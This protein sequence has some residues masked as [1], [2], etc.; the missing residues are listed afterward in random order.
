MKF[1][2][3]FFLATTLTLQSD[4]TCECFKLNVHRDPYPQLYTSLSRCIFDQ[5][6]EFVGYLNDLELRLDYL[7]IRVPANKRRVM[8]YYLE[9]PIFYYSTKGIHNLFRHLRKDF[10]QEVDAM[11]RYHI[12]N[13]SDYQ[14]GKLHCQ[15]KENGIAQC[16]PNNQKKLAILEQKAKPEG[17]RA[18]NNTEKNFYDQ[19]QKDIE[20]CMLRHESPQAFYERGTYHFLHG[21]N[22]LAIQDG[23]KF[24]KLT[25]KKAGELLSNIY[26]QVGQAHSESLSYDK[27]ITTL[28]KAIEA[29]PEN[30]E[31]VFERAV[32]EFELGNFDLSFSDYLSSEKRSRD[33]TSITSDLF[34]YGAGLTLGAL[35]GGI[36]AGEDFIPSVLSSIH[37]LSQGLW[38]FAADPLNASADF[39][40]AAIDC[41]SFIREHTPKENAM[42]LV[43]E[44]RELIENWNDL[45]VSERGGT[46]G[47]F[48]GKYGVEIF[49]GVGVVKGMQAYRNLRRANQLMTFEAM[50]ISKSNQSLIK[51]EAT[52]RAQNRK[53]IL[54]RA[55]LEIKA[56]HQNKHLLDHKQYLPD[57]SV[58]T[59]TNLEELAHKHAGKGMRAT[60]HTPGTSGYT[61]IVN[62][63][64]V[65]GYDIDLVTKEKTWTTWGKIHYG[66]DGIHIV[67]TKPRN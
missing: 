11:R 25:Q 53:E 10:D 57:R 27:A 12:Q 39:A 59:H 52:R 54:Q 3:S 62:F 34:F 21:E 37:G 44:L 31:A 16:I 5:L 48:L 23:M 28:T 58:I 18:I 40:Q 2:L 9:E 51:A 24:I 30:R 8:E 20:L 64:E 1:L 67:P 19:L 13:I 66:K 22:L 49:A 42:Q 6:S 41:V 7:A 55:N 60:N 45:G 32:A 63:G 14:S 29:N 65:I 56:N 50:A 38:A 35:E 46:T 47:Y 61:E 15:W 43:P 33:F 36:S 26:L 17:H 4:E